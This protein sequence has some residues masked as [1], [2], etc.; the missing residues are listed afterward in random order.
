VEPIN[1][2]VLTLNSGS[3]TLTGFGLGTIKPVHIERVL[4]PAIDD[5]TVPT[6]ANFSP[7]AKSRW[8]PRRRPSVL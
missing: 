7:A 1:N 3:G 8:V 5:S 2:L 4:T 6:P